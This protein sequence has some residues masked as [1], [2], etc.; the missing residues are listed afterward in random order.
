MFAALSEPWT[1]DE[2]TEGR[3][4]TAIGHA[5]A[6]ETW[7]S[8]TQHGMGDDDAREMMISFVTGIAGSA[9]ARSGGAGS[10]AAAAL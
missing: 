10:G 9:S 2:S 1:V 7:Q 5:M 3:L 8:L 6:F 4:Q